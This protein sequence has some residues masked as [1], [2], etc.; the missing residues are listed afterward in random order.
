MTTQQNSA[1]NVLFGA[2]MFGKGGAPQVRIHN[3]ATASS[4]VDVCHKHKHNEIDTARAY[5]E[6]SSK[7]LLGNMNWQGRGLVMDTKFY[8]TAHQINAP[9]Q[10][11]ESMHHTSE[12][13]S[14]PFEVTFKAVNDLYKEGYF[15]RLGVS[16]YMAWEVAQISEL[17]R[18]NG[19]KQIDVYQGRSHALH[20]S[21]EPELFRCLRNY[22]I[23]FY[24]YHPLAGGLLTDRYHR[25]DKVSA[26]RDLL[27]E[28]APV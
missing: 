1:G 16:N 19:W 4:I 23:A 15:K 24:N 22:G 5:G 27:Q 10:N 13:R 6:G 2:M 17:C 12:D 28:L 21:V 14:G 3:P 18:A 11:D 8:P 9:G 20:R 7:E 26:F 25:Q